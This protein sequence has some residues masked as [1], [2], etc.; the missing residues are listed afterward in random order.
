[1]TDFATAQP[2]TPARVSDS[3]ARKQA[4]QLRVS[5]PTAAHTVLWSVL[6]AGPLP[7][8]R[9]C[10]TGCSRCIKQAAPSWQPLPFDA[11]E[12]LPT[13]TNP[14]TPRA[15]NA[16]EHTRATAVTRLCA[17]IC[18]GLRS[19]LQSIKWT[20]RG[21]YDFLSRRHTRT[22]AIAGG[23]PL[24]STITVRGVRAQIID[25]RIMECNAVVLVRTPAGISA[26]AIAVRAVERAG[27]WWVTDVEL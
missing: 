19:P 7:R 3:A 21:A 20:T 27:S 14:R 4:R 13:E 25:G 22:R 18:W 15:A 16:E 12:E 5:G 23:H 26:R 2:D 8:T 9:C 6:P 17:E 11:D 10:R 24:A 1:M